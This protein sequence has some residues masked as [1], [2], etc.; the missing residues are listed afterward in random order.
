MNYRDIKSPKNIWIMGDIH[1]DYFPVRNFYQHNK[2]N[3]SDDFR[4]NVLILLGDVGINYFLNNKDEKIK[5]KLEH[6]P[7][8]YFCIRGNHELR[9]SEL[10]EKWPAQWHKEKFFGN[11]V[12]V[13]DHHPRILYALDGGG[14]YNINGKSVLVIPGAYSVDKFYRLSH[15]WTWNPTEQLNEDEKKTLKDN[16]KSHY[17]II[18]SHTCPLSWQTY[19]SDL[20]LSQV[21]Q[22]SVDNSMEQFLDEVAATTDYDMWYWGHYHDNRDVSAVNG[23][24]MFHEPLPF[25]STYTDYQK[26]CLTF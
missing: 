16:L 26:A 21:D 15:G 5:N 18:L 3:L 4:E 10:E 23:V 9:P 7:F 25:G 17:D 14:E 19:I 6:F 1:G 12:Y 24:M 20:F 8:T 13:E 11:T 22:S 2:K